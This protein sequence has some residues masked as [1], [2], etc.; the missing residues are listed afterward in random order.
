ME[1]GEA[2]LLGGLVES[3]TVYRSFLQ[4]ALMEF[5]PDFLCIVPKQ[6]AAVG[7]VIMAGQ[8]L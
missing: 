6:T 4:E 1:R 5:M 7:A 2:V 8:Q 3:D